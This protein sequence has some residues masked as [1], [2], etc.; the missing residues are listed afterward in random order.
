MLWWQVVRLVTFLV[1]LVDRIMTRLEMRGRVYR[2]R[3]NPTGGAAPMGMLQVQ[4]L[5]EP[6]A[7]HVVEGRVR[8]ASG[9]EDAADGD[10]LL[11]T[12]QRPAGPGSRR[13]LAEHDGDAAKCVAD[14]V[15]GDVH[16]ERQHARPSPPRGVLQRHAVRDPGQHL[17]GRPHVVGGEQARAHSGGP[18]AEMLD[19]S[20]QEPAE[21]QLPS[22]RHDDG[23]RDEAG[24]P[25]GAAPLY[26]A[27]A[28]RMA[29]T[30]PTTQGGSIRSRCAPCAR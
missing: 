15:A 10:P 13:S 28:I 29:A 17:P 8:A 1:M 12:I 6:A 23:R 19:A 27:P 16:D 4:S 14:E 21:V 20:Q 18:V 25:D 2:R 7:E 22:D 24:G 9:I 30:A 5:L 3:R 26:T 11:P